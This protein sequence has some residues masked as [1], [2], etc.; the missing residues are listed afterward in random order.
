MTKM[1][2]GKHNSSRT[3][4]L[5]REARG[6]GHKQQII[7]TRQDVKDVTAVNAGFLPEVDEATLYIA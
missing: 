5:S 7:T 6:P 4:Y 1:K 3:P 2:I